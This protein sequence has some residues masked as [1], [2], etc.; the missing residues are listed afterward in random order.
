MDILGYIAFFIGVIFLFFPNFY[1]K[2]YNFFRFYP[3]IGVGNPWGG[4]PSNQKRI[5]VGYRFGQNWTPNN[6]AL[7]TLRIIGLIFIIIGILDIFQ[8]IQ[9]IS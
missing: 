2:L 9:I 8:I 4:G 7:I 5:G 1:V 6:F 3:S